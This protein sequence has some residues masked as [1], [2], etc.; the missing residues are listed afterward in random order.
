MHLANSELLKILEFSNDHL[1]IRNLDRNF[2]L[3]V[4]V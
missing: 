2:D 3:G 4:I 1:K